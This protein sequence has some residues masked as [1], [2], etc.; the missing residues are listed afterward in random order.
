[1]YAAATLPSCRGKGYFGKILTFVKE[2]EMTP[3]KCIEELDGLEK[4]IFIALL[5]STYTDLSYGEA[6][7][8]TGSRRHLWPCYLGI[9]DGHEV[10]RAYGYA[11]VNR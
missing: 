9:P 8:E 4:F 11:A 1:M 2:H 7:K 5:G 10:R 3:A 6:E